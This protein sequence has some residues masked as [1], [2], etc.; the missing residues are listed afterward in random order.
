[1]K[2]VAATVD[3]ET[4]GYTREKR[5]RLRETW[6]ADMESSVCIFSGY[7]NKCRAGQNTSRNHSEQ[8]CGA[9]QRERERETITTAEKINNKTQKKTYA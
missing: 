5:G 7:R 1:M 9:T 2:R 4:Q 3:K 6:N 8:V